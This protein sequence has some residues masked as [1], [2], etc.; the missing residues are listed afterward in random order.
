MSFICFFAGLLHTLTSPTKGFGKIKMIKDVLRRVKHLPLNLLLVLKEAL[1]NDIFM[2]LP[3]KYIGKIELAFNAENVEVRSLE[4]DNI[5]LDA[6]TKN[7]EFT[8]VKNG[9]GTSI[10]YKTD[11]KKQTV[12]VVRSIAFCFTMRKR[13]IICK[14]SDNLDKSKTIKQIHL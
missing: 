5:E 4:F 1:K 8:A 6:K 14:I 11:I 2:Q 13:A 9:I 7:A 12:S 10:S 3:N